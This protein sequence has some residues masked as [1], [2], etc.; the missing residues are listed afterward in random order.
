MSS[1]RT[2]SPAA[3]AISVPTPGTAA[4]DNATATPPTAATRKMV[5]LSNVF[6]RGT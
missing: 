4:T 6:T 2:G 3:F 1:P 5:T